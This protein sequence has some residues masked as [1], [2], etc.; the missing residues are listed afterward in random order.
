MFYTEEGRMYLAWFDA[1]RKKPIA[2]KIVEAHE[3]YVAK[4]GRQPRVCLVNPEDVIAD[5]P[6]TLRPLNNIGRNCFWIGMDESDEAELAAAEAI[7]NATRAKRQRRPKATPIAEAQPTAPI[8]IPET[9]L[10]VPDA[11]PKARRPRRER[12]AA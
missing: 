4:F 9:R 1:D 11:A 8:V 7:E 3:R 10:P 12:T 6:I 5:S 2:Q